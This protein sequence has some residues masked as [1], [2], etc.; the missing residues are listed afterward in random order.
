M[1]VMRINCAHDS[2]MVWERIVKHLRRAER[3]TG[4]RCAVS[5]DLTGPKLRTGP[6]APGPA[7]AKWRP[8]RDAIGRVTEP[9]QVRLAARVHEHDTDDAT[10]PVEGDLLTKAKAGDAVELS[11]TR[12]RKRL[13]RVVE[14]RAGERL[15]ET[16]TTAYLI[17]GTQLSLRR[18][19]RIVAKGAVGALPVVEQWIAL[20]PGDTLEILRGE[21]P[22]R[23]AIH[24]HDSP[25]RLDKRSQRVERASIHV[26]PF[27]ACHLVARRSSNSRLSDLT[28]V[29]EASPPCAIV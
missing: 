3:E 28:V 4:N 7:V 24:D 9:A 2:P 19:R 23:D 14:V 13:L 17:P 27:L 5:F 21:A 12:G 18:N 15:C 26:A 8:V 10:I 20:R 29:N 6:I 11:D 22:G 16:D 1:N 25:R